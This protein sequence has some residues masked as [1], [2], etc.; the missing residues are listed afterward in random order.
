MAEFKAAPEVTPYNISSSVSSSMVPSQRLLTAEK[1]GAPASIKGSS[2]G[3][4]LP[5]T[6]SSTPALGSGFSS[7]NAYVP[8][9]GTIGTSQVTENG[10]NSI[11]D[12]DVPAQDRQNVASTSKAAE[13][14]AS[15]TQPS[16]P[17][18]YCQDS[19]MRFPVEEASTSNVA[20]NTANPNELGLN[21][22]PP[23]YS[24]A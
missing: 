12:A 15:S 6:R 14:A 24:E 23:S 21:H 9:H 1:I 2:P 20:M 3:T 13:A 18:T 16:A 4:Y 8:S 19:G 5:V 10:Q 17:A 11:A 22:V 7:D